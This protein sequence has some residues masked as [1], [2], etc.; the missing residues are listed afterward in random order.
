MAEPAIGY[1]RGMRM[2]EEPDMQKTTR[3][4]M[5]GGPS[6]RRVLGGALALIGAT[7]IR[8][9]ALA[10]GRRAL[11]DD[12]LITINDGTLTLPIDFTFPDAPREELLALLAGSGSS[13]EVLEPDCNVTLLRR[14]NR[15]VIFDAGS[16]SN[17]VPTAGLLLE[18]LDE[19]G[20]DPADVTDVVFTHAHPDH[21][22]GVADDFD[23]LVFPNASYL[24]GQKEWDFW[25]SPDAISQVP[26]DRQNFVAGAQNRFAMIED[27]IG[28]IA[29]GDE[30]LPGVEAVDTAG[31]TPGHLSFLVH[32]TEESVLVAGDALTNQPVTFAHPEWPS[33]SDQDPELAITT[34]LALLD[35]LAADRS[36]IIGYHMPHPGIGHVERDGTAY[37]FVPA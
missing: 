13:T 17:F 9:P 29:P 2:R 37:R 14:G 26:E 31:H 35:R 12:E 22:W 1:A 6:R 20:I 10:I 16:G 34:R 27:R 21:L 23:E 19:A 4:G 15:L 24:I 28:F 32:G 25:S 11:G 36:G 7:A 18:G 8:S 30:V 5:A 33:G 3:R